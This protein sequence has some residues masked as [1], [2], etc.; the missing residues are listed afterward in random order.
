MTYTNELIRLLTREIQKTFFR[1]GDIVKIFG[2]S[3]DLIIK[4]AVL[5]LGARHYAGEKYRLPTS[6]EYSFSGCIE[7]AIEAFL[8]KLRGDKELSENEIK[9]IQEYLSSGLVTEEFSKLLEPGAE[10]FDIYQLTNHYN[11]QRKDKNISFE[12][13]EILS[14]WKEFLKGYSFSSRSK[15]GFREFLSASYEEGSFFA[16]ND[17]RSVIE[18]VENNV[19]TLQIQRDSLSASIENYEDELI[20]YKDWAKKFRMENNVKETIQ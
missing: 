13:E 10:I 1:K 15:P 14:A 11:E 7:D 6:I 18:N 12:P 2:S 16:L 8:N 20:T 5:S 9:F 3:F 4:N 19:A 17:I